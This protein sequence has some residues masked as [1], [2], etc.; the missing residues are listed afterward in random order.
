LKLRY[1]YEINELK[2][3]LNRIR[4]GLDCF[5]ISFF[6]IFN[7][8]LFLNI[9]HTSGITR[10]SIE[11]IERIN[12]ENVRLRDEVNALRHSSVSLM[13]KKKIYLKSFCFV[14]KKMTEEENMLLKRQLDELREQIN[15]KDV[16]LKNYHRTIA[17]LERQ[18][19]ETENVRI[20]SNRNKMTFLLV[21]V[22]IDSLVV[23]ECLVNISLILDKRAT[24]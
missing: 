23:N 15:H 7:S 20:D 10:Q 3:Q 6:L 11:T 14:F 9:S 5:L 24:K 8:F 18:L 19:N 21:T 13:N 4:L 17:N 2:N 22:Q 16:D 12:N 1:E